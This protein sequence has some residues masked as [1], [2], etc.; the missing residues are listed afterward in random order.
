MARYLLSLPIIAHRSVSEHTESITG[1]TRDI[2]I[3]GLYFTTEQKI[4]LGCELELAF[5][6][7]SELTQGTEVLVRAKGKVIRSERE[8]PGDLI[9]LATVI[10]K[11]ET[12]RATAQP[13]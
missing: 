10:E 13:S 5:T 6:L 1:I 3:R 12:V 8:G 2:S 7:P 4:A 9:G 11:Y